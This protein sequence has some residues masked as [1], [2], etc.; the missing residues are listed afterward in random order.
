[1]RY[2][3]VWDSEAQCTRA[4]E[5]RIHPAVDAAFGGQRPAVEPQ[6][7]HLDVIDVR[8]ALATTS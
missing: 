4:F 6:T 7:E 3:D 2:I 5:E 1:L 8:G